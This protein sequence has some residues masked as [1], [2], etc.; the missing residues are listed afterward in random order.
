MS[1]AVSLTPLQQRPSYKWTVVGMLW[2]MAFFNY[3]DRQ[4][5]SAILPLIDSKIS[6]EG[7]T[8]AQRLVIESMPAK[9]DRQE[10]IAHLAG[11]G[12]SK[13]VPAITGV[14]DES[15]EETAPD[16]KVTK[17]L[18][19]VIGLAA[20]TDAANVP[21]Q[22][23]ANSDM[24]MLGI[25]KERQ[26]LLGTAFAYCYGL[27]A[28]F[29]GFI[30]DRVRRRSA[31][32]WGLQVWSI[33][34]I[35]T[36]LARNYTQLF[37]FRAA[38]GLG[39]AV[40]FPASMSLIS[41]YHG[42]DTRSRAMAFH[43]T[44]VYVGTILGSVFAAYIGA[45]YGWKWSFIIFGTMGVILGIVV[46]NLLVEPV[47]GASE[48]STEAA[49]SARLTLADISPSLLL[50]YAGFCCAN[51]VAGVVLVWMPSYFKEQFGVSLAVG[52]LSATAPI[53]IAS[54]IAA[55]L[56][57][58]LAD[59]L[60]LMSAWGRMAVQMSGVFLA[61]PCVYV[62]A[63]THNYTIA[64]VALFGW[65]AFKGIYDANIFA[66]AY[67]VVRPGARGAAAGVMNMVGWLLGAAP[68]AW[69]VGR[70]A[71][72]SGLGNAIAMSSF[73]YAAAGVFL[74]IGVL[75]FIKRDRARML[76]RIA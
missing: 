41:D 29:A 26:G 56:G 50:A 47:R 31:V 37:L 7:E 43:Q 22:I 55:P 11:L 52:A 44:S 25:D 5:L 18:R 72:K 40:Y 34:C 71:S 24:E 4:A 33:I 16:G 13:V 28:P 8:G 38:E 65:G 57:G 35:G 39:E 69:F 53:Q 30:V 46:R 6:V 20:G 3:A 59:R 15:T 49:A 74:L 21:A 63:T 58:W 51:F 42:K 45:Q 9:A 62:C 2:C 75:F 73:A 67:D 19:I 23:Y 68:A 60:A 76:A 48:V 32:L 61:A 12:T 10:V 17:K 64:L 27:G 36:G 1:N 66:T 14:Q 70:E 54:M